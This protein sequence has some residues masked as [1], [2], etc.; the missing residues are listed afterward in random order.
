MWPLG[1]I[2][3][4]PGVLLGAPRGLLGLTGG[5]L[6]LIA[7]RPVTGLEK[8]LRKSGFEVTTDFAPSSEKSKKKHEKWNTFSKQIVKKVS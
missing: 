1:R 7:N 8:Q 4:L 6:G 3:G 5:L 2:G